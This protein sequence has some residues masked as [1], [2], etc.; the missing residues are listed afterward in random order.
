VLVVVW[1]LVAVALW[2]QARMVD[3]YLSIAGRLGLRGAPA[4]SA[5]M[6]Q[7]YPAFAAD[8]QMWVRHALSLA[9]GKGPQLRFTDI[10]NAPEGRE[11]HWNSAWAWCIAGAGWMHHLFTGLPLASATERATLWLNP[12]TMFV[13]IVIFSTWVTTRA[14]VSA[15]VVV[16]IAMTCHDRILEGFFPSYVDHHGLLTV[17]VFG[18]VLG[19]VFMGGGWWQE[20]A[21]G[22]ARILPDSP[23]C[24]RNAAMF[25][26]FCGAC[27]MWVSAASVIPPI[28]IVATAGIVALIV[29]GKFARQG[30]AAFDPQSWRLWGRAGAVFSIIFYLI[31]YFPKHLGMHL[32]PNHPLHALAWLG[33]GELIAEFGVRW[34]APRDQRLSSLSKLVWPLIAVS[35]AP[36]VV[37][38]G[39]SKVFVVLDPFMSRLHNDYIQEFL[40][41]W[42]TL[43]LFD[44]KGIFQ[45]LVVGSCP[46]IAAI[47]TLTYRRR[48]TPIVLW[49][50]TFVTLLLTAMAWWQS[51]WLL[52]VT[53]SL[54]CLLLVLFTCWTNPYRPLVRW[55]VAMA[56]TVALFIP[57]L[58]ARYTGSVSD[59]QAR[60]VSPKDAMNALN[61]DIAVALRNS[62]PQGDIVLLTSPNSS[63]G[64]G[65]YGRFKTLGTLYWENA[66][67]LKSAA[68]ILG[69][70]N[71]AE[72]ATLIRS[73]RVTHL[74]I[75]S[76]ENFIKEYFKLLHPKATA[77]EARQSFG[78]Q[79]LLDKRVPQWLQM[80]PYKI[81]DDMRSLNTSVMLFKVNFNQSLP[82]AIY[83]VAIWQIA[84][85]ALEDA[86]RTLDI[87][88]TQTPQ[89]YPPWLRRGELLLIRHNWDAALEHMLKGISLAPPAER[90]GLYSS[91]GRLFYD[92][93]H[94]A[95][96][97]KIYRTALADKFSAELA[98]YLSWLLA[99]SPDD[100]LR[101]G[102]E[103]LKLADDALAV[104]GNSPTYLNAKAAALAE[105]RRFPEA[106]AACDRAVANARL[107]GETMAEKVFTERLAA[108]RNGQPLR[109]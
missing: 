94:H 92:Q 28:A 79:L 18:L 8:A 19:A 45:V 10:D 108:L 20:P 91:A 34:M 106:I 96:A 86:D 100:S 38:I 58:I 40:P 95:L 31:E 107:R 103:A 89:L 109:N 85:D 59:V 46:L 43:R 73:H 25:S 70:R 104:D 37:A 98:C 23:A 102:T 62:Q 77:E 6:Q 99:T 78:Q 87:L 52:N 2:Q 76:D 71:E 14:G 24:A 63:V 50:A 47:A 93:R 88:I 13:L 29:Q 53:G 67:G 55:S 72:A 1:T 32:E 56:V 21:P 7:I 5:P 54:I 22:H 4:S 49:F 64:I 61:R 11:V 75:V 82:E 15:G 41:M 66:A 33:G 9:D 65:Y 83:N 30:G 26:G 51:R 27:G 69:A 39:G 74:A 12:L 35:L 48:Q 101:N 90:P 36:L 84:N 80:I 3:D 17:A 97:I 16:A 60:R 81:P 105:L 42:S 68:S 44:K 57:S